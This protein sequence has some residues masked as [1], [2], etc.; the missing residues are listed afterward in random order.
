MMGDSVTNC[1]QI[2]SNLQ[3]QRDISLQSERDVQAEENDIKALHNAKSLFLQLPLELKTLIYELVCGGQMIHIKKTNSG[4]AHSLCSAECSEDEAQTIFDRSDALYEDSN[5]ENR[6]VLNFS[7]LSGK[8]MK[9]GFLSCCRQMYME[10]RSVLYYN[11]TFAFDSATAL[12][13]FCLKTPR[14]SLDIIRS[15]HMNVAICINRSYLRGPW[16]WEQGFETITSSIPGLKRLHVG[17]EL[18]YFIYEWHNPPEL[19]AQEILLR[20]ILQAGKLDLAV[21]TVILWDHRIMSEEYIKKIAHNPKIRWTLAQKQEWSRYVRRALIHYEDQASDLASV[22]RKALEE[23]RIC[24][25]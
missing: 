24:R 2:M 18:N 13:H 1:S 19:P 9:I 23:G 7:W 20:S 11:N 6:Y 4:L 21:A 22:K 25:L 14:H 16:E 8:T 10:S 17:I 15:V 3:A 5:T 12:R